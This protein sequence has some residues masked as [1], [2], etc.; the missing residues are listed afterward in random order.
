M[1]GIENNF[2]NLDFSEYQME[3]ALF[4]WGQKEKILNLSVEEM[5]KKTNMF[6]GAAELAKYDTKLLETLLKRLKCVFLF[7]ELRQ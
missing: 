4:E 5:L 7:F 1:V 2:A 6:P 3:K